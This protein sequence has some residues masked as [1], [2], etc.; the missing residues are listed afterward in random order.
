MTVTIRL[1]GQLPAG[2]NNGLV[3][4]VSQLVDD[5]HGAHVAIVVLDCKQLTRNTD[6]ETEV[7]LV[8]IRAIEPLSSVADITAARAAL[9][10]AHEERT[11]KVS[12]PFNLE[13]D[14]NSVTITEHPDLPE[15]GDLTE[16]TPATTPAPASTD[17]VEDRAEWEDGYPQGTPTD[18]EETPEGSNVTAFR[19]PFAAGGS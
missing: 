4:I 19:S 3:R 16:D 13:Q 12:L 15:A 5:P 8:R 10:R 1:G 9:Q 14:G 6:D 11:G 2:D 17:G 18:G 7:P